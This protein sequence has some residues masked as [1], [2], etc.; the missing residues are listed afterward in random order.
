MEE[1]EPSNVA[2]ARDA[3]ASAVADNSEGGLYEPSSN[4]GGSGEQKKKGG[5]FR[6]AAPSLALIIALLGGGAAMFGSQSMQGFAIVNRLIQE[7]NTQATVSKLRGMYFI[8]RIMGSNKKTTGTIFDSD[9]FKLGKNQVAFFDGQ[10]MQFREIELGDGTTT[11]VLGYDDGERFYAVSGDSET[12]ARVSRTDIDANFEMNG[13]TEVQFMDL[14]TAMREIPDFDTKLTSASA[15]WRGQSSG[16]YDVLAGLYL[17]RRGGN[18]NLFK[19]FEKTNNAEAD[20]AN[21]RETANTALKNTGGTATVDGRQNEE[22]PNEPLKGDATSDAKTDEPL[23]TDTPEE[24]AAKVK[25]KV[26]IA[27]KAENGTNTVC[28]INTIGGMVNEMAAAAEKSQIIVVASQFFEAV[29]KTQAGYGAASPMSEILN[30]MNQVNPESGKTAMQATGMANLFG[31]TFNVNDPI[32]QE[33]NIEGTR[34]SLL[35]GAIPVGSY[36]ASDM[37]KCD[38]A[39]IASAGTALSGKAVS[40]VLLISGGPVGGLAWLGVKLVDIAIGVAVSTIFTAAITG[41]L[42]F[43]IPIIADMVTRNLPT[44][45]IGPAMGMALVAGSAW[46]LRGMHQQGGG[47][48]GSALAV[49]AF[50]QAQETVIAEEAE[51]Q[52]KTHSAFD[53]SSQYTFMGSLYNNIVMLG[54]TSS[55]NPL[56]LFGNLATATSN[57]ILGLLPTASALEQTKLMLAD[58]DCPTANSVGA[59]ADNFCIPYEVSDL[60]TIEMDPAEVYEIVLNLNKKVAERDAY[61]NPTRWSC[62]NFAGKYCDEVELDDDGNP[63]ISRKR[64]SELWKYISFCTR[65]DSQYGVADGNIATSIISTGNQTFDNILN[66]VG[67]AMDEVGDIQDFV[68]AALQEENEGWISGRWCLQTEENERWDSEIKYYQRYVQ[69]QRLMTSMGIVDKSSVETSLEEDEKLNPIDNSYEGIIARYSGYTKDQVIAVLDILDYYNYIAEYDPSGLGPS[70]KEDTVEKIL[71]YISD[72][73]MIQMQ[74]PLIARTPE[75]ERQVSFREYKWA[76]NQ[77]I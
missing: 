17:R 50:S 20:M 24:V 15:T 5:F 28:M 40:T 36:T 76:I 11:R 34:R 52:R 59:V 13:R 23:R 21:F 47:T 43:A 51:Y 16:W 22:D 8:K 57:S 46:Y 70:V 66:N 69:D 53:I 71:F 63:V 9:S 48:G 6:K 29:Q 60:S 61:G 30:L 55:S 32:A 37:K 67:N 65:R 44:E 68:E 2:A 39:R 10:N 41:I 35:N 25:S 31:G 56:T 12:S 62:P 26:D 75:L 19:A 3:E 72:L 27:Q 58:G 77:S 73:A 38:Y 64:D 18:R 42:E 45:V 74:Q 54:M 49:A 33:F 4:S 1:S 7:D 14:N